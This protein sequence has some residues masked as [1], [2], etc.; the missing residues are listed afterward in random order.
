M[1]PGLDWTKG[2]GDSGTRLINSGGKMCLAVPLL[3]LR[4]G[5]QGFREGAGSLV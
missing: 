3:S 5:Y 1:K 4:D 2:P